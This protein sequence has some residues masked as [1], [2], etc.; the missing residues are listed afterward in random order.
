MHLLESEQNKETGDNINQPDSISRKARGLTPS[1]SPESVNNY[2]IE[3]GI[4]ENIK[5]SLVDNSGAI[6]FGSSEAA[7]LE[8]ARRIAET[9]PETPHQGRGRPDLTGE[10]GHYSAQVSDHK[11]GRAAE[12]VSRGDRQYDRRIRLPR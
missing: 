1:D 12:Q 8:Q 9:L 6:A 5:T 10:V 4:V 3:P 7:R 2:L 11:D